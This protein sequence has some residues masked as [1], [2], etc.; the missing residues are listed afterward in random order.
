MQHDSES[1]DEEP[2]PVDNQPTTWVK[3]SLVKPDLA[4]CETLDK[5]GLDKQGV[6]PYSHRIEPVKPRVSSRRQNAPNC[7]GAGVMISTVYPPEISVK[8]QAIDEKKRVKEE[9]M[10]E[11]GKFCSKKN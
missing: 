4:A 8:M 3:T 11:T 7:Y 1:T 2:E 6:Q 10:T 9:L 5:P